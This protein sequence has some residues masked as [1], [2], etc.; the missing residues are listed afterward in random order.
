MSLMKR[1]ASR[2]YCANFFWIRSR[3]M[4]IKN[5]HSKADK[6]CKRKNIQNWRFYRISC[7]AHSYLA[8]SREVFLSGKSGLACL[9][10]TREEM[11]R[12]RL[13]TNC[14]AGSPVR[15][16]PRGEERSFTFGFNP[17]DFA[18]AAASLAH[19]AE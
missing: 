4:R 5:I 11:D 18:S 3:N 2:F 16:V 6:K 13:L 15:T 12:M 17:T 1:D 10:Y 14:A 19:A 8:A 9:C 7:G